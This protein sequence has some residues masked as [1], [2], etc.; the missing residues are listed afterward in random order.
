MLSHVSC[1][2]FDAVGTLIYPDP[3]VAEVYARVGREHGSLFPVDEVRGRFREAF[4]AECD[5]ATSTNEE[6]ERQR[7][8][9]IVQRVFAL[10]KPEPCFEELFAH[11]GRAESWRCFPDVAETL[12]RLSE[13]GYDLALASNF[14]RRLHAICDGHRE[15]GRFSARVISSEVGMFKPH[16]GF[17]EALCEQTGRQKH[18]VLMVGDDWTNDISGP[19]AIG[20]PAVFLDRSQ[21]A[22][23][24]RKDNVPV[25]SSLLGLLDLLKV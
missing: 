16:A 6:E 19:L 4:R 7:W 8:R 17:F 3:P 5:G 23:L 9:R 14:D 1:I 2:A 15:L 13:R 11:F 12:R 22:T 10:E 18:E 20:M 24:T 25:I 21:T